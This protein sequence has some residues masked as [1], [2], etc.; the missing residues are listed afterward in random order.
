MKY[1]V[2]YSWLLY[3]GLMMIHLKDFMYL[4]SFL[5]VA[6][7]GADLADVSLNLM[8]SRQ[9]CVVAYSTSVAVASTFF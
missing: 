4:W 5:L 9:R 1:I 7:R 2:L 6:V 8:M 3:Y